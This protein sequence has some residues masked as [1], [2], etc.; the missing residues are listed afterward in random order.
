MP[1]FYIALK[2][3]P[4]SQCHIFLS[5]NP[6]FNAILAYFLLSEVLHVRDIFFLFTAFAGVFII[7]MTK[8]SN[9]QINIDEDQQWF[10]ISLWLIGN[11]NTFTYFGSEPFKLNLFLIN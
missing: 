5:V 8:I 7:N 3:L 1:C 4:T 2:Y 6:F 11:Y 10:G 9:D